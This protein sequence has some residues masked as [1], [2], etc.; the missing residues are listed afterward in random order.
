MECAKMIVAGIG[1]NTSATPKSL[2]RALQGAMDAAQIARVDALASAR[3][4]AVDA[5]L[6][7]FAA[8]FAL[9]LMAVDVAGITT[10]S[11][12]PR[13]LS[14]YGTGSLA[15]AA[16]LAA[17]GPNARLIAHKTASPCGR[18]TCAIAVSEDHP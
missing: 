11:Q 2:A 13:V 10:P 12:S 17:A 14:L 18:A 15:E 5:T 6:T 16:A 1:F 9:P 8:D 3:L 4:K 7:S